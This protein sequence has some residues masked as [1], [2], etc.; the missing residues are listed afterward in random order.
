[1]SIRRPLAGL[2]ACIF[3]CTG[4]ARHG[5]SND[6][7]DANPSLLTADSDSEIEDLKSQVD[8]LEHRL[9]DAEA[10][11]TDAQQAG[12][13]ANARAK[14]AYEL[15]ETADSKADEACKPYGYQPGCGNSP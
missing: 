3:V 4:C 8:A 7:S 1:M 13:L 11:A 10:A 14:Q 6:Q 5:T 2:A 15:A 9:S 12:E